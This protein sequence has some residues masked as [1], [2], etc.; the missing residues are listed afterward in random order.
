M[1]AGRMSLTGMD[2]CVAR[3][4]LMVTQDKFLQQPTTQ[5]NARKMS[6]LPVSGGLSFAFSMSAPA[7][8]QTL[9]RTVRR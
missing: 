7:R 6:S 5:P 8:K 3:K 9:R 4:S 1:A 2:A